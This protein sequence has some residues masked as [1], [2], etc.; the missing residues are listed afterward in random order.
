MILL[1]SASEPNQCWFRHSSRNRPIKLAP[2]AFWI[3]LAGWNRLAGLE[4][5]QPHAGPR[6][7]GEQ[8][9]AGEFRPVVHDELRRQAVAAR[10]RVER[11]HDPRAADRE[12]GQERR[13]F[14]RAV[15]DNTQAA[16]A[17]AG[18]QGVARE[19]PPDRGDQ[20]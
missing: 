12:V 20:R 18:P 10:E 16:K 3:G 15:I 4:E 7:L 13:E 5:A 6:R 11:A 1:A 8:G 14:A 17:P 9:A 19:V 2:N